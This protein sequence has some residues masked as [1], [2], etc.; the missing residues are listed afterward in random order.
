MILVGSQS[1]Q[2]H[3]DAG[4]SFAAFDLPLFCVDRIDSPSPE[5]DALT[6][7]SP[8]LRWF[9]EKGWRPRAH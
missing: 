3:E 2:Q 8:F 1:L 5:G 7:P 6:L 4:F 9:A